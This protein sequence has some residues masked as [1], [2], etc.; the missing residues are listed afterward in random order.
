M[1]GGYVDR[2]RS[3]NEKGILHN[4]K[5]H[6]TRDDLTS[7]TP[8]IPANRNWPLGQ[9]VAWRRAHDRDPRLVPFEDKLAVKELA[10]AA[11]V[12]AV[13]TLSLLDVETLDLDS[14][15]ALQLE[16]FVLKTNH[17]CG[18]AVFVERTAPGR[19]RSWGKRLNGSH[20]TRD[21]NEAIQR[22]FRWWIDEFEPEDEW[23]LAQ[24]A[25]RLLFAEPHLPLNDDYKVHVVGG[26][27]LLIHA[28]GGR[29]ESK[30][31]YGGTFDRE[32]RLVCPMTLKRRFRD[33]WAALR[34]RF[35]PPDELPR[36]LSHAEAMV[37]ARM[38]LMRV[39]F[40]RQPDGSFVLGEAASYHNAGRR[41]HSATAEL[42]LGQRFFDEL[43]RGGFI[44][45]PTH[46]SLMLS[47]GFTRVAR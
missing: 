27:V 1:K 30:G 19:Y 46:P 8:A 21:A 34:A 40:Y 22:H 13:P 26:R 4:P 14:H 41:L 2:G 11:G 12:P 31:L 38:S 20:G 42:G 6:M 47:M 24:V 43:A 28:M 15:P 39:D 44:A 25:P 10:R 29:W 23:A 32:W 33:P 18:D 3:R 16:R 45:P 36:L 35:P 37:P 9:Y 7:V 5:S 17:G